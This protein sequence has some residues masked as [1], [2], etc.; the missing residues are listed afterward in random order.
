[1]REKQA[2]LELKNLVENMN[3]DVT[4][5]IVEGRKDKEAL[6]KLGYKGK[7]VYAN[8]LKRIKEGKAVILTDF[9]KEGIK[10]AER[11]KKEIGERKIDEFFREKVGRILKSISRNDIQ[12]ISNLCRKYKDA[13]E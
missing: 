5:V 3:E 13:L 2:F 7:I 1:M 9:D 11:I 10:I 4:Y 12:S 8:K 6:R